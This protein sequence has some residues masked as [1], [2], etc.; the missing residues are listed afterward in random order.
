MGGA[1]K[2]GHGMVPDNFRVSTYDLKKITLNNWPDQIDHPKPGIKE[3]LF[4]FVCSVN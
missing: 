3:L 1:C 2:S 4:C